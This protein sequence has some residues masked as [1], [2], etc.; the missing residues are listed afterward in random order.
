MH[1]RTSRP[2][3][4][5]RAVA[6]SLA[7]RLSS[8]Y[9]HPQISHLLARHFLRYTVALSVDMHW[10]VIWSQKASPNLEAKSQSGSKCPTTRMFP[11]RM[12]ADRLSLPSIDGL[13]WSVVALPMDQPLH[14][15]AP[16]SLPLTF[17]Y[18][19]CNHRIKCTG[20]PALFKSLEQWV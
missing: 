1:S 9:S 7:A 6:N 19:Q 14:A 18:P 12:K 17:R 8:C 20:I 5:L 3:A 11:F 16:L 15:N 4:H 2:S 10:H 13:T